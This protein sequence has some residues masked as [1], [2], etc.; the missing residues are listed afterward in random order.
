MNR[1]SA[2]ALT[3]INTTLLIFFSVVLFALLN[4]PLPTT[5][6]PLPW[7]SAAEA[8]GVSVE[9]LVQQGWAIYRAEGCSWCHSIAGQGSPRYPLDGAADRNTR[10]ELRLWIVDPQQVRADV[11]K[12][13]YDHLSNEEVAALVAFLQVLVNP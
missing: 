4:N 11:R 12:R 9:P 2:A 5:V 6:D 7:E 8:E 13:R 1:E 3:A 10:E